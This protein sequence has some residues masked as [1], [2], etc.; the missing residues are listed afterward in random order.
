[1]PE[2]EENSHPDDV[3]P[4]IDSPGAHDTTATGLHHSDRPAFLLSLPH[5]AKC[6]DEKVNGVDCASHKAAGRCPKA[7]SVEFY[8]IKKSLAEV[9]RKTCGFCS[10]SLESAEKTSKAHEE[11]DE[12]LQAQIEKED[13]EMARATAAERL[14]EESAQESKSK[15]ALTKE[16]TSKLN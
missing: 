4:L 1:M 5:G 3:P 9:C 16:A 6:E 14:A 7:A 11:K 13:E 10:A 2:D 12:E 15:V 8:T